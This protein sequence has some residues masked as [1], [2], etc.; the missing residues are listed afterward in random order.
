MNTSILLKQIIKPQRNRLKQE[1]K[2]EKQPEKKSENG[3]KHIPTNTHSEYQWAKC[4]NHR[5]QCG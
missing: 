4:S 3:N 2:T 1:G 5:A